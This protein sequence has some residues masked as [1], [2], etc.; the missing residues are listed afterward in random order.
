MVTDLVSNGKPGEFA[1]CGLWF[2]SSKRVMEARLRGGRS[3]AGVGIH[4]GRNRHLFDS[5][6]GVVSLHFDRGSVGEAR[7]LKDSWGS[8]THLIATSIGAWA[9]K[10]GLWERKVNGLPAKVG[11]RRLDRVSYEV[12]AIPEN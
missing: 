9:R 3:N 10:N 7:V 4:I 8:C 6:V 2:N 11:I 5:S 1:V 12:A